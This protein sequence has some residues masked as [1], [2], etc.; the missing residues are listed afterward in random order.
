MGLMDKLK[1]LIG[2]E[3]QYYDEDFQDDYYDDYESQEAVASEE[4]AAERAEY[5]PTARPSFTESTSRSAS[6]S[7]AANIV[8]MAAVSG[9]MKICIQEP[10][11]YDD[12]PSVID[13]ITTG[14]TVVLNLEM[15]EV[16]KKRQIFDFVS[17]G[18]YALNG[19]IQKVTKDIYVIVPRG[20]EVDGKLAD[21][22]KSKSLYQL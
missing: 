21:T 11:T 1:N 3:D 8:N 14:Q 12:G 13:N 18:V 2:I 10:L 7:R 4:S 22:V 9:K 5:K 15:L 16:D 6:S 19:N 20:V 17:G